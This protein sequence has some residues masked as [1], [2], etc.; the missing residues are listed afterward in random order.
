MPEFNSLCLADFSL[1][2]DLTQTFGVLGCTCLVFMSQLPQ[3]SVGRHKAGSS[4]VR[5]AERRG[6]WVG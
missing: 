6:S 1:P 3:N 2:H 5:E 4:R